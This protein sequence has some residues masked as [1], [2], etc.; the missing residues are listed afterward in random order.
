LRRGEPGAGALLDEARELALATGDLMRIAPMAAARAEAAWLKGDKEQI[1]REIQ[2]AYDLALQRPAPWRLGELSL[3]L[4]RAGALDRPPDG[5][6][7]PYR[8]EIDGDWPAAAAAWQQLGCPYEQAL[9]LAQGDRP[10][11]LQ[12]LEILS[13]L[14][15]APAAAIVRRNLRAAGLRGI[16]QGPRATTKGNPLGLTARE[17]EI[18][19][20]LAGN[21]TNKEIAASLHISP[22]TV[23]HHVVAV[24][25]KLGVS[26][27]KQAAKH[28]AACALLAQSGESAGRI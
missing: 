26:T 7:S 13:G 11:Q 8:L 24:L 16:P 4:W 27:R 15:A 20:L 3:W 21:L 2:P 1:R 22:K 9:A 14:G 6:A 23:D 19:R 12:A 17:V 5:I 28:P 18:L 10:A 25:G